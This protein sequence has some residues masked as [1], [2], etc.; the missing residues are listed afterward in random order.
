MVAAKRAAL[1]RAHALRQSGSLHG[2]KLVPAKGRCLVPGERRD[3]AQSRRIE[4][5]EIT[6]TPE[7]A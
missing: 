2:F 4:L 6:S 3:D 5:V 7:G 1:Q